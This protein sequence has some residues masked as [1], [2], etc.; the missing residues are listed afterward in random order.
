MRKFYI[1]FLAFS[2]LVVGT[3]FAVA[4]EAPID[5][6]NKAIVSV[7]Q[8]NNAKILCLNSDSSLPIIRK[9]VDAYL[10]K[11]GTENPPS[12]NE[13]AKAAYTLFPCPFSPYRDELRPV[14]AKDIE[15]VWLYPEASQKL[16]FGPKSPMWSKLAAMPIKCESVAFYPDGETRN[17]KIAGQ[18][19]CPFSSAKDMDASSLNPKVASWQLAKDGVVKISRTDVQGHI[20]EWEIFI[21][22]K[23]FEIAAVQFKAGDLLAYLRRERGN[24]FNAST[25]F[26]HLQ[27]LP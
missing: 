20:E 13:I 14:A 15:G 1:K 22:V 18:M 8:M 10:R 3:T 12:A 21:V 6:V 11:Q 5:V 25:V 4:Q 7:F 23:V 16:R 24:D 27:R 2:L 9:N 26:R 17:T 19:A